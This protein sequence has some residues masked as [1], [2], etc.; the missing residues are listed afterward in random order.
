LDSIIFDGE[1]SQVQAIQ[2][3]ANARVYGVQGSVEVKLPVGFSISSN[4][5]YQKGEEVLDDGTT[6]TSRHAAPTFGITRFAY[7]NAK[8]RLEVYSLYSAKVSAENLA[9]EE[10]GKPEIYA[11]DANG[12]SF[13]PAW[14]TLNL[15]GMYKINQNFSVNAGIENITNR[16]YRPYSSGIT[17]AGINFSIAL[18]ATF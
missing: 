5:N 13:T 17:A 18:R 12:D 1:L 11:K 7:T 9:F 4:I 10:K 2:N 14:Y 6:S 16:R 8:V 3:A 15:R